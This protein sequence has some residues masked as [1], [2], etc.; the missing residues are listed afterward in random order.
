MLSRHFVSAAGGILISLCATAANA[1][2][3]GWV[4]NLTPT[5]IRAGASEITFATGTTAIAN[6]A[7]C[8]LSEFYSVDN[9]NQKAI[10]AILLTASL[11]GRTVNAAV[12]T[13]S[14][15]TVTNRPLVT[16]VLLN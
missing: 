7:G 11:T 2:T 6:P 5:S 15:S 1:Q 10:L 12:V 14:C 9:A 13:T 16:D 4:N 3:V 8:S